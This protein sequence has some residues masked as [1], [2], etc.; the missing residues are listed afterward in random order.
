MMFAKNRQGRGFVLLL[1]SALFLL[2]GCIFQQPYYGAVHFNS[3]PKGAEVVNLE[4]DASLGMT[5]VTVTWESEDGN[6]E[7]ITVEFI[8][9]G[10][11]REITSFWIN[12]RHRSREAAGTE[13][14]PVTAELK[15]RN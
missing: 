8:K 12:M 7:K 15:K 14:Q 3:V 4:D 11:Q 10:Y 1:G 2:S 13:L 5:P 6:P 9:N